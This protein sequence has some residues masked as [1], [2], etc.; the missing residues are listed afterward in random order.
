MNVE[1]F[2]DEAMK[3]ILF[4]KLAIKVADSNRI[5]VPAVRGTLTG[6]GINIDRDLRATAGRLMDFAGDIL[7]CC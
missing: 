4:A 6:T 2:C 7:K 3:L 1:D 5:K